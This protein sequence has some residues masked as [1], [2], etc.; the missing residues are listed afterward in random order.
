MSLSKLRQSLCHILVL[1]LLAMPGTSG[2]DQE[3]GKT[4]FLVNESD[5]VVAVNAETGQFF[6]LVL[7]AKERVHE[8]HVANGVAILVTNQR[9]AGVS[10]YPSGWSSVR[11]RAGE[12]I[13]STEAA[14]YSAL[15]VTSD[16]LLVFNG[17]TG[18]WSER[19]R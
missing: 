14:D 6:D 12:K 17:K 9:F 18:A 16:R 11:R 10:N 19:R 3:V 2:A 8:R 15:V 5:R 7:S 4:I 1:L 13:V